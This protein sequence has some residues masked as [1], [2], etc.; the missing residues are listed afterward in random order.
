[1][2]GIPGWKV[3]QIIAWQGDPFGRFVFRKITEVRP[4]PAYSWCYCESNGTTY[5]PE[6][7]S[8]NSN[9]VQMIWGWRKWPDPERTE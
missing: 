3:G 4:G 2:S 1:M 6:Y 7:I 5:G 9:D 8:G